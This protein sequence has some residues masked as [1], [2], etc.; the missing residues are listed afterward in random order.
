M[1]HVLQAHMV[2]RSERAVLS[3]IAGCCCSAAAA[4]DAGL[5]LHLLG[6]INCTMQA[7]PL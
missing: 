6:T 5:Q 4:A 3:L 2:D 7:T 1:L